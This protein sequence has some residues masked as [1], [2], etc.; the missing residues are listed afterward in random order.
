[1]ENAGFASPNHLEPGTGA[2]GVANR[3]H[4][5][6]TRKTQCPVSRRPD[7]NRH[8][9]LWASSWRKTGFYLDEKIALSPAG[10]RRTYRARP[11]FRSVSDSPQNNVNVMHA[12]M[13]RATMAVDNNHATRGMR[14]RPWTAKTENCARNER[15]NKTDFRTT[16]VTDVMPANA[17]RP[18][19]KTLLN[20]R[21]ATGFG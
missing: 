7:N 18:E 16:R 12:I 4:T 6:S 20:V 5:S 19:W 14:Q 21:S 13:P 11:S 15:K 8:T 17:R 1:M 3:L 10:L 9:D 2:S